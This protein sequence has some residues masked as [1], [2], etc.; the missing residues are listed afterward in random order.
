MR[1]WRPTPTCN[2]CGDVENPHKYNSENCKNEMKCIN[3]GGIDHTSKDYKLC[4]KVI[5]QMVKINAMLSI[6]YGR[7][8]NCKEI[9]ME[10]RNE[11]KTGIGRK[12]I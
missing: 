8:W 2:V 11:Y 6:K 1:R 9:K 4:E 3:C 7:N 10:I 12:H 5:D